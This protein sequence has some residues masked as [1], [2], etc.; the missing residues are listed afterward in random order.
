MQFTYLTINERE[1]ADKRRIYRW[2][3]NLSEDE[4]ER[5]QEE[6]YDKG[7]KVTCSYCNERVN[8]LFLR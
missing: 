4:K 1:E 2:L 7:I 5:A 8:H 6:G 3:Y